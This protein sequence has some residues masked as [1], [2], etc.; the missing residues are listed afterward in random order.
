MSALLSTEHQINLKKVF[1]Y[2]LTPV[3]LSLAHLE[4]SMN[5]TNKAKLL[6]K[7]EHL[8]E[9]DNPPAALDVI[10]DT[11]FLFHTLKNLLNTYG[12]IAQMMLFMFCSMSSRVDLVFDTYNTSLLQLTTKLCDCRHSV[13]VPHTEESAEYLW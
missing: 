9:N 1:T 3:T 2:P 11:V 10:V 6:L 12:E 8:T 7:I 4:G 13:P 5:K